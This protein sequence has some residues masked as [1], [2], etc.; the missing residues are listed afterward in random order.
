[1]A[2]ANTTLFKVVM[3][4]LSSPV[5]QIG[6]NHSG[7]LTESFL[8]FPFALT[9]VRNKTEEGK[10]VAC[11]LCISQVPRLPEGKLWGNS[12]LV[13]WVSFNAALCQ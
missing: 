13:T 10:S 1:M 8:G 5:Q 11:Y 2:I 4:A 9:S 3:K 7:G 12:V 6:Q